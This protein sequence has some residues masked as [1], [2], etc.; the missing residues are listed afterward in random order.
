MPS[1]EA[2]SL[3]SAGPQNTIRQLTGKVFLTMTL[4]TPPGSGRVVA[5]TFVAAGCAVGLGAFVLVG[6][7]FVVEVGGAV[8]VLVGFAVGVLVG[9]TAVA[10]AVA[11]GV[12]G[13]VVAVEVG[14]DGTSVGGSTVAVAGGASAGP[15]QPINNAPIT[16]MIARR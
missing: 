4:V 5:G 3:R 14:V 16:R 7:G 9:G 15:V 2:S 10:V 13:T 12:G 8:G 6:L 11:V 1:A